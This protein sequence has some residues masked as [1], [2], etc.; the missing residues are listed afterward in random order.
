M[1]DQ[2]QPAPTIVIAP[3]AAPETPGAPGSLLELAAASSATKPGWKTSEFAVKMLAMLMTAMYAG[4]V[5]TD[6]QVTKAVA[7]IATFTGA[8]GYTW[9]RTV[10]K[11]TGV[12]A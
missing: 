2:D 10:A 1:P 9:A 8:L 11:K 4:G 7:I 5:F 6:D 12:G 3:P